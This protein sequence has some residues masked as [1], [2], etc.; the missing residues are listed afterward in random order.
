MN[1]N[2]KLNCSSLTSSPGA[3]SVQHSQNSISPPA[4]PPPTPPP[5][6]SDQHHSNNPSSFTP[7]HI[8]EF[9]TNVQN[10]IRRLMQDDLYS[11]ISP[12]S[13]ALRASCGMTFLSSDENQFQR[14]SIADLI[15]RLLV[16]QRVNLYQCNVPLD[17]VQ[18]ILECT[19]AHKERCAKVIGTKTKG[20]Q[21]LWIHFI[22]RYEDIFCLTYRDQDD[23]PQVRLLAHMN[24]K[25]GDEQ[26]ELLRQYNEVHLVTCIL[27]CL[28]ISMY[29]HPKVLTTI[30]DFEGKYHTLPPNQWLVS[31]GQSIPPYY[32]NGSVLRLIKQK[33]KLFKVVDTIE[34]S[35]GND[36]VFALQ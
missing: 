15:V 3:S 24:W 20:L 11:C 16:D 12:E 7:Q 26:N 9:P 21:Q 18:Q 22:S 33:K 23:K 2:P 32:E 5:P 31:I 13:V 8:Q 34:Y 10:L 4:T 6:Y 29:F 14:N 27:S 35:D 17:R 30:G 1:E 19:K 36:V 28:Y 25:N